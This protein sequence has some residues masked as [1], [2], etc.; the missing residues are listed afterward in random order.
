MLLRHE[1][2]NKLSTPFKQ[3]PFTGVQKNGNSVLV[4]ADGVQ[5]RR[6]VTHVKK[7][8]ERDDDVLPAT[9]KSSDVSEA[10]RATQTSPSQVCSELV[11]SGTTSEYKPVEYKHVIGQSDA[12]TFRPSTVKRV[13]SKFQ[14]Y[15]LGCVQ[16]AP[17]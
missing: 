9:S 12:T 16:L 6:N 1:K 3:S 2:E 10:Q 11:T 5:N 14:D 4:E 13:P 7:Y 15:V 17:G 8:L